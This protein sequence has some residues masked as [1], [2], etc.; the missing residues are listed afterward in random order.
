MHC[1]VIVS[2]SAQTNMRDGHRDQT[3]SA[4][5]PCASLPSIPIYYYD[6]MSKN[7]RK[8]EV[9]WPTSC[10]HAPLQCRAA[11]RAAAVD[12][13][14]RAGGVG[15]SVRSEERGHPADLLGLGGTA[16]GERLHIL[17]PAFGIAELGVRAGAHQRHEPVGHDQTGVDADDAQPVARR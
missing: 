14:D 16:E 9:N 2:A 10:R 3:H 8:F 4:K 5:L 13:D 1:K 12:R 7:A 17:G 11:T 15:G 6:Y